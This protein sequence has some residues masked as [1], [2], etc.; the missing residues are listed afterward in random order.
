M[1]LL[2]AIAFAVIGSVVVGISLWVVFRSL[3]PASIGQYRACKG[4]WCEAK[5]NHCE[6]GLLRLPQQPV[7]TYSNIAYAT[8]GLFLTFLLGTLPTYILSITALY[9]CVGSALY[10]ATSTRWAGS[11]DVSSMY[12][13]FSALAAYA[14]L[15]LIG[16][17][18][19]PLVA[20]IM[21]AVAVLCG[22]FLRYRYRGNMS[23]KIGIFL[24][25]TYVFTVWHLVRNGRSLVDGYLI[26]SLVLFAVAYVAWNIDKIKNCPFRR[27]GHGIWHVLT[28]VAIFVLYYGVYRV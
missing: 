13:L 15:T 18:S 8:G 5:L 24:V 25:L 6:S 22:Y 4:G 9:L 10:H 20:L 7:N 12:A 23:L 17:L 27:W 28:A 21:F 14:A 16:G 1:T 19:D 11:L 3:D 2:I 26:V